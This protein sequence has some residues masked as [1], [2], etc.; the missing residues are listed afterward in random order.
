MLEIKIEKSFKKDI[1][2]DKKSGQYSEKDFSVLKSLITSLQNQDKI[3]QKYKTH[4]LKGELKEFE[5]IHI[6]N[7]WLLIYKID[8]QYLNLVMI[9]KHTQVYKKFK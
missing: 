7:N 9:G 3:D 8:E 2:R 4:P 5:S 6:K 1:N